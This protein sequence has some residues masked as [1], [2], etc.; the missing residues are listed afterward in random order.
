MRFTFRHLFVAITIVALVA[1]YFARRERRREENVRYHR[2]IFLVA[3]M[4]RLICDEHWCDEMVPKNVDLRELLN[5]HE[6]VQKSGPVRD[7]WGNELHI[8]T[9]NHR[10]YAWVYSEGGDGI[11][12]RGE[13]DDI[14]SRICMVHE[15]PW[16]CTCP[17]DPEFRFFIRYAKMSAQS[18]PGC[19]KTTEDDEQ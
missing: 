11:D 18:N 1:G 8:R 14:F 3:E 10:T 19:Q 9:F 4:A 16:H 7:P 12:Q 17:E 6:G 5:K 13:G 15:Y 2:C